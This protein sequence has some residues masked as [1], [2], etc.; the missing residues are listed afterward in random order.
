MKKLLLAIFLLTSVSANAATFSSNLM[1]ST[2]YIYRGLTFSNNA[3]VVQGTLDFSHEGFA[4]SWFA[5]PTYTLNLDSFEFEKDA[6]FDT[7]VSYS[8]DFNGLTL[9]GGFDV[10]VFFK[11]PTND[12]L[13]WA[14]HAAY[15]DF[16]L[17]ETYIDNFVRL[18]TNL[19]YTQLQFTPKITDGV[20]MTSHLGYS[21]FSNENAVACSSYLDYKLGVAYTKETWYV[22]LYYTNTFMRKDLAANKI[23]ENDGA[24]TLTVIKTF[25]WL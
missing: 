25:G 23:V 22:E 13:E 20:M 12:M 24:L 11:N 7:F 3:P 17:N 18:G 15:G 19:S 16:K 9:T 14:G 1:L 8:R 6:E 2:N 5:G 4:T 21:H 10:Y